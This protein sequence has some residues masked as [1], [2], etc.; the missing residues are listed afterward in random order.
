MVALSSIRSHWLDDA[1][2]VTVSAD[3]LRDFGFEVGC[4]VVIEVSQGVITIKKIHS[5]DEI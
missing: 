1:P 2:A 5:E 4:K 3:W